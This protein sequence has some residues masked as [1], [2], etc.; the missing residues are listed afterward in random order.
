MYRTNKKIL[1]KFRPI[2][3]VLLKILF[4]KQ[5]NIAIFIVQKIFQ[6]LKGLKCVKC[7]LKFLFALNVMLNNYIFVAF[8]YQ[9]HYLSQ[10]C[11]NKLI[12]Q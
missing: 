6:I 1:S 5:P 11:I 8:N 3:L 12:S 2:I 9:M 7:L 4:D 10:T